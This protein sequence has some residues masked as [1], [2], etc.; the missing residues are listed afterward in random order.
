MGKTR[1]RIRVLVVDDSRFFRNFIIQGLEQDGTIEVVGEAAD[2]YEARDKI[3]ELRPDVMTLDV[4]MPRM[5]GIQFLKKLIPQYP[6]P[7]VVVSSI[8]EYVFDALDVG[9]VDFVEKPSKLN[10]NSKEMLYEELILKIKIASVAKLGVTK[11]ERRITHRS[12]NER[13]SSKGKVKVIAIGA[14]TGGTEAIFD[15]LKNLKEDMP[16]IVIVQHMPPDFTTMY[17]D[18][19]NRYCKLNIKEACDKDR[20]V[21]GHVLLA[22]GGLHMKIEKDSK[23]YY[24]RCHSGGKVNGH[25]PSVDTLFDSVAYH[26]KDRAIGIILTGMGKDGAQGLLRMREEGAYTVGQDEKSSTIYGMPKVAYEIGAVIEQ[27]NLLEISTLL[28]NY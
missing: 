20:L 23:G 28:S 9:A 5:N 17:A 18:R 19:I 1:K 22:P 12:V 15:V 13:R 8:G 26:M 3:I 16:P 24:V 27:L 11:K 6:M 21:R 4:Q 7:V 2:P 25:C 10:I 14:S